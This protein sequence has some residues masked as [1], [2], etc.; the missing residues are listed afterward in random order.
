MQTWQIKAL[1]LE[2]SAL[3]SLSGFIHEHALW[4]LVGA[5]YVLMALLIWVLCGGL[6]RTFPSQ[7]HVRAGIGII[8]QPQAPPTP[9][10]VII[11]HDYDPPDC[12]CD[13]DWE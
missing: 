9:P 7:P 2:A 10:P 4:F 3:D 8:I 1:E 5:I 12:D 11:L 13:D 6:R